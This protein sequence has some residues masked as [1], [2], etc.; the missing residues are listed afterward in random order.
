MVGQL[1]LI[2]S[3][4]L[5][6]LALLIRG[7]NDKLKILIEEIKA[8]DSLNDLK[9][10]SLVRAI[11][12][13]NNSVD[14]AA[15]VLLGESTVS[16]INQLSDEAGEKVFV[17]F[18]KTFF[19]DFA[20][21]NTILKNIPHAG[22]G[23]MAGNHCSSTFNSPAYPITDDNIKVLNGYAKIVTT[24]CGIGPFITTNLPEKNS[25]SHHIG[26]CLNQQS[27]C[28]DRHR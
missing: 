22:I 19:K 5:K 9:P 16:Y 12:D 26:N 17:M 7:K 25:H 20:F 21:I 18:A 27:N 2:W 11:K 14:I 24:A 13:G 23:I 4:P 8:I 1:V 15:K 6:G 10:I 28:F 3:F